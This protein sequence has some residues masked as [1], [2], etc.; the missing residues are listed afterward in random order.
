MTETINLNQYFEPG[1]PADWQVAADAKD[2]I[3]AGEY[4][5]IIVGTELRQSKMG[6]DMINVK[7]QVV[8]GDYKN[9]ILFQLYLLGH[10]NPVVKTRNMRDFGKMCVAI[11]KP[12]AMTTG[13]LWGMRFNA[14]VSES[15]D[16][17]G[18]RNEIKGYHPLEGLAK[19]QQATSQSPTP[20]TPPPPPAT[21]QVTA[22]QAP[23]PAPAPANPDDLDW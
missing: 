20:A 21:P 14:V 2:T 18:W 23:P 17:F 6:D 8:E 15:E 10:S 13:E 11:G 22:T 12:K 7:F 9:S 4:Q 3:P 1:S 5:L 16:D 19:I